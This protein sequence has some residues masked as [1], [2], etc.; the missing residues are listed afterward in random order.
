MLA[1]EPF[2]TITVKELNVD[3]LAT[4][5]V[6]VIILLLLVF[7]VVLAGGYPA[8]YL[9]SFDPI[10]ALKGNRKKSSD[11]LFLQSKV[12]GMCWL[13]SNSVFVFFPPLC[14]FDRWHFSSA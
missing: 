13:S 11:R 8:F 4:P 6:I 10:E 7:V 14:R 5:S 1:K 3:L 12:F 2:N 9:S